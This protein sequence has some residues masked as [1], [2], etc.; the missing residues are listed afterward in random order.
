MLFLFEQLTEG[1]V[2]SHSAQ[3]S[4]YENGKH[5]HTENEL[6]AGQAQGQRNRAN[7]SLNCGL[8]KIGNDAEQT[9]LSI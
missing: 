9:L 6:T 4:C 8:G 1:Q 2:H 3:R 5:S 7:G